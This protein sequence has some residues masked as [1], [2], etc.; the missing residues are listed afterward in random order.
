ML[1]LNTR[2][3]YEDAKVDLKRTELRGRVLADVGMCLFSH[4][5]KGY[6]QLQAHDARVEHQFP[7]DLRLPEA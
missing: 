6:C 7:D 4:P 1:K 5:R 3:K 2:A